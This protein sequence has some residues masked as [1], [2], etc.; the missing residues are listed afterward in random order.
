MINPNAPPVSVKEKTRVFTSPVCSNPQGY[1][2][3]VRCRLRPA[4]A[5][6]C[7]RTKRDRPVVPA[8]ALE[9]G[10]DLDAGARHLLL[11]DEVRLDLLL[12][13]CEPGAKDRRQRPHRPHRVRQET[14]HRGTL[15]ADRPIVARL[16]DRNEGDPVLRHRVR[17]DV[18]QPGDIAALGRRGRRR[19]QSRAEAARRP[20]AVAPAAEPV[21]DPR[22]N[23]PRRVRHLVA[24][25]LH[26]LAR[27]ALERVSERRRDEEMRAKRIQPGGGA[28]T[29]EAEEVP[30]RP[31]RLVAAVCRSDERPLSEHVGDDDAENF[32]ERSDLLAARNHEPVVAVHQ[33][34]LGDD[35]AREIGRV[36]PDVA[37]VDGAV[38]ELPPP[39][40]RLSGEFG[41]RR[42]Y[43][44]GLL[45]D[46]VGAAAGDAR[47]VADLERVPVK[48]ISV[49]CIGCQDELQ[50]ARARDAAVEPILELFRAP[51][52]VSRTRLREEREGAVT[53][54]C[55]RRQDEALMLH[56]NPAG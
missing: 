56:R 21:R 16:V 6:S 15:Q 32:G 48:P 52:I 2:S 27:F 11:V 55:H 19:R 37:E 12:L 10:R 20:G 14:G 49:I 54:G 25:E 39:R 13:L 40:I 33:R 18:P 42:D 22:L 28:G 4:R 3:E 41:P 50:A 29:A 46:D 1:Q 47:R 30:A 35:D 44:E 53:E 51:C 45:R 17:E 34:K 31:C 7:V 8:G 5:I 9:V 36:G 43:G 26:E 38:L 23:R 24:D